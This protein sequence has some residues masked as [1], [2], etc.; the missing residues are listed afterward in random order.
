MVN[1][2]NVFK[3]LAYR[4]FFPGKPAEDKILYARRFG[5]DFLYKMYPYFLSFF[6]INKVPENKEL[7]R[8]WFTFNEIA[9]DKVKGFKEAMARYDELVAT[10]SHRHRFKIL[11][12]DSLLRIFVWIKAHPEIP[13]EGEG[14]E[15]DLCLDLFKF[16]LLFNAEYIERMRTATSSTTYLLENTRHQR[17]AF[18]ANFPNQDLINTKYLQ[19]LT[20]QFE[21]ADALLD[22]FA[23]RST[24]QQ[25]L[26]AA[27]RLMHCESKQDYIQKIAPAVYAS[28]QKIDEGFTD[29]VVTAGDRFEESCLLLDGLA[30]DES[31]EDLSREQDFVT[32]RDRP[33]H[34]LEKGRYRVIFVPFLLKKVY[35]G[36]IFKMSKLINNDPSFYTGNFLS[37]IRQDFSEN[38]LLYRFVDYIYPDKNVKKITGLQFKNVKLPREP[39]YYLRA[40]NNV[41]LFESKDF[42]IN[43]AIKRTSHFRKITDELFSKNRLEKAIIQL[44]KNIERTITNEIPGDDLAGSNDNIIHPVIVVHDSVYT[45]PGLNYLVH[46]RMKEELEKLKKKYNHIFDFSR[47]LP[48]TIIEIDSLIFLKE[49]FRNAALD[50]AELIRSY[51]RQVQFDKKTFRSKREKEDHSLQTLESFSDFLDDARKKKGILASA[52]N[53]IN[54]LLRNGM[55]PI[56]GEKPTENT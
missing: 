26:D 9:P 33:F 37:D 56:D 15:A 28:L 10:Y 14:L 46:E 49:N 11:V 5:K 20:T 39:D 53:L 32:L 52:D 8:K 1:Q 2:S 13:D 45:A 22:F 7:L 25:V 43:A 50:L 18:A 44:C 48:V 6:R 23:E 54:L 21:K 27:L 16:Y 40:G 38:V 12:V 35:N 4:D 36:L 41:I 30:V 3:P 34:K 55:V 24:Y 42:F 19:L 51:H 31:D 17:E 29:I 47:L